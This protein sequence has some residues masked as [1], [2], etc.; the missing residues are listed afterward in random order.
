MRPIN[1]IPADERRGD[2]APLRAGPLSYVLVGAL[3][4]AFGGVYVLV[5]TGNAISDRE[6]ELTGLEHQLDSTRARAEALQSFTDFASLEQSRT[7]TVSDLARSRFDWERV[8]RELALVIPADVSLTEVTGRVSPN[9]S[10]SSESGG[11]GGSGADTTE[12]Q[13]PVLTMS[14]CGSSH[15][16]VARFVAALRDIDGV[17][18]VGLQ[19]SESSETTDSGTAGAESSGSCVEATSFELTVAFDGVAVDP[20]TGGIAPPVPPEPSGDEAGIADE[21]REQAASRE[22]AGSA[23]EEANQAVETFVPGA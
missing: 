12:I 8:M 16:A 6:A 17:T 22:S 2:R 23:V 3:L 11:S 5:S 20:A 4:L 9:A 7:Q 15:D 14:G 21:E 10:T 1:L 19:S 18:R 13:A